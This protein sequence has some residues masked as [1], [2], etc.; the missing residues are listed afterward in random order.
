M[1]LFF[2]AAHN[3]DLTPTERAALKAIKGLGA[4]LL[5]AGV[6]A[7]W[8]IITSSAPDKLAS[9]NWPLIV[10]TFV[11]AVVMAGLAAG[12]KYVAAHFEQSPPA[13]EPAT[14]LSPV[15]TTDLGATQPE[16]HP[17]PAATVTR[18]ANVVPLHP[19]E[20]AGP[21]PSAV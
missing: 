20:E 10:H 14:T 2:R 1:S 5:L 8:P 19:A 13:D 6:V 11:V 3:L 17:L 15:P 21:P 12:N 18:P 7:I 4:S 16:T 9:L